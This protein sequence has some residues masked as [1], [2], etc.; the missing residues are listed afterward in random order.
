MG[1][2]RDIT[3][4]EDLWENIIRNFDWGKT[5]E[6][7]GYLDWKWYFADLEGGFKRPSMGD[8]I[9][10]AKENCKFAYDHNGSCSSG[11]LKATYDKKEDVLSLEF[12]ICK[13]E[14]YDD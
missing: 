12:V 5:L 2:L 3:H 9:I 14:A 13:W 10:K 8:L 6:V 7:L 1:V 11:G 4:F